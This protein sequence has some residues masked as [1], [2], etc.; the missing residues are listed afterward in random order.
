MGNGESEQLLFNNKWEI[1]QLLVYHGENKL[2]FEEM[3]MM[4]VLY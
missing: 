4:S 3:M 1:V 2:Y